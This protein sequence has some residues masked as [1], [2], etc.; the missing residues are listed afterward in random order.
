MS[1]LSRTLAATALVIAVTGLAIADDHGSKDDAKALL[2]K[3]AAHVASAGAE[4]AFA[5][6]LKKD[7]GFVDRD[8]YVYCLDM[9]GNVLAHGGNP[10]LIGKNLMEITD[11]DGTKPIKEQIRVVA[12]DGHGS[13]DYKWPSPMS[14]KIEAKSSFFTKVADGKWCGVGY[15]RG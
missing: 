9:Q 14:K 7:G 11:S 8:L 3:A 6:F 5:D 12:A 4:T 2:D 1:A 13:L 10:A 15:Y